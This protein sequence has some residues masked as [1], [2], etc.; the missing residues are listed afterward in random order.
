[1]NLR[2]IKFATLALTISAPVLLAVSARALEPQTLFNFRLSPSQVTG[3]LV[4]GPD[5]NFYGTTAQ[6]GATRNGAIFRVAPTGQLTTVASELTN[7]CSTLVVGNDG[8]LYG[9]TG[10]DSGIGF[11]TVFRLNTN[12]TLTHFAVFDGTNGNSPS[13]GLVLAGDG[14][15][16]GVSPGGGT[17]RLGALFRVSPAGVIT[18]LV[19]FDGAAMG[20]VPVAQLSVGPDGNLYGLTT[21]RG[22]ADNGT[23]FKVTLGGSLTTLHSF[24][25]SDGEIQQARLTVGPDKNLYGTT[26]FG[27]TFDLGTI[28][29]ITTNGAFSTLFS[30]NGA[31]GP[32]P[33]A[34]L[35]SGPG[36]VLFGTTAIGGSVDTGTIFKVTTNGVLTILFSFTAAGNSSPQAGL[37]LA[38]DGNFY[39]CSRGSVFKMTP[40]GAFSTLAFLIP[41]DG[42][43][44]LAGLSL[45]PDGNFYG[46]TSFGGTNNAGTIFKL[47]P[48]GALTSLSSFNVT[49]GLNPYANLT[50][51][52][53]GNFYGTTALGGGPSSG[54][55][56]FR[57]STNGALTR[58]V[59]LDGVTAADPQ[60][61]LTLGPDGN[62]YGTTIDG[63]TGENGT[64]FRVS[65]NGAF[66]SLFS[67]NFFNGSTPQGGLALGM[68]GNFYG[69]ANGGG[70]SGFF[71]GTVF[72]VTPAG[73]LTTL[74]SFN[75]A[76][77][78]GP[79]AGLVQGADG[80][81]Y[82]STAEGGDTG[83][84]TIF[85]IT[86]NGTM[87]T[88][89]Q[90]H[91]TDGAIPVARMIFGPD[92]NLYGTTAA[93]GA[94]IDVNHQGFG[95]VFRITTNGVFT[96]LVQFHGTNGSNPQAALAIGPDGNLYGTTSADGAGGGG[97][98]FRVVLNNTI[99]NAAPTVAIIN[100][101]NGKSFI[102]PATITI[103]ATA[104]DSDGSVTNVQF[105]DGVTSLGNVASSPFN[106]SVSLGVGSHPLIAV[107]TD[108]RG[109][110]T[111]SLVTVTGLTET[112]ISGVSTATGGTFQFA[113]T[114]TPGASFTVL[115]STNIAL[116]VDQ[117]TSA[118]AAIET[119]PGNYHFTDQTTNSPQRF[120]R[121]RSP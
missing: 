116:P 41:L 106:L 37:L 8:Q 13:S 68:D 22:A 45:G 112:L 113:F 7:V 88:L 42:T 87:A 16:Y 99:T 111:A 75:Q 53:D 84:G 89:F 59:A 104:S 24:Q 3:T 73:A 36:N 31:T 57:V 66:T 14:N 117:W 74:L 10:T 2:L 71:A 86:T 61:Q 108:N 105:F 39:G 49:N 18:L 1:M 121:L 38:R 101:Q 79:E 17:N 83:A 70:S 92:G 97:T 30:F 20:A 21:A 103:Q 19:S 65:T 107:A 6:A 43:S 26:S 78:Q 47:T 54:G 15:F 25:S 62:F 33:A 9:T 93:G 28:Y 48:N 72:R 120:Y 35:T 63:G 69:T 91:S 50:L 110:T 119:T 109:G 32:A 102:A 98:I 85:K 4:E 58:L 100:P 77:G 40:A 67:F 29:K 115:T 44:P 46:T 27:G 114:N 51:G 11:G 12:G 96:S 82:G 55:V 95:T 23:I 90:F 81:L 34:E 80:I 76:N 52:P 5:G 60:S 64:V 118:G 56:V 94:G